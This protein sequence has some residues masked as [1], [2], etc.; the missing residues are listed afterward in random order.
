MGG[1]SAGVSAGTLV[2]SG[3]GTRVGADVGTSTVVAFCVGWGAEEIAVVQELKKA[4]PMNS[5]SIQLH[6]W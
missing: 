6:C 5:A 1:G 2:G 3:V 4:V